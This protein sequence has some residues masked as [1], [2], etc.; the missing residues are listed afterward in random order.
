MGQYKIKCIYHC[1]YKQKV[2]PTFRFD[3][4]YEFDYDNYAYDIVAFKL[5]ILT[6]RSSAV[7]IV[8]RRT[9][10]IFDPTTVLWTLVTNLVVVPIAPIVS[11]CVQAIGTIIWK[12]SK[13]IRDEPDDRYDR[14][15]PDRQHFYP[16]DRDNRKILQ[17]IKWKQLSDDRN[18]SK[19]SQNAA[20]SFTVSKWRHN[21]ITW[22]FI[23]FGSNS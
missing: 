15:R 3:C 4:E 8:N 1:S 14:D 23:Y 6:W 12:C 16:G 7:F 5:A 9:A 10:T 18:D 17:A 13:K 22:Y 20:C 21:I 11:K 2:L 19:L